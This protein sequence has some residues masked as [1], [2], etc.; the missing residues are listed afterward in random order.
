MLIGVIAGLI[1]LSFGMF[2]VLAFRV[3]EQQ[4]HIVDVDVDD[5]SLPE[6]ASMMPLP[7]VAATWPNFQTTRP[8]I[9]LAIPSSATAWMERETR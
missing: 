7:T 4:R 6:G 2:G 9:R 5:P 8:P 3:S 1:G